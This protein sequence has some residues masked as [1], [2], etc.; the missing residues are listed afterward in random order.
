MKSLILTFC[1]F[2]LVQLFFIVKAEFANDDDDD[3]MGGLFSD[4]STAVPPTG[5]VK[6]PTDELVE[7]QIGL[8]GNTTVV[9]NPVPLHSTITTNC[10]CP[11]PVG[12]HNAAGEQEGCYNIS[13]ISSP[14]IVCYVVK[15]YVENGDWRTCSKLFDV[16][17]TTKNVT[18]VYPS[19]F[20]F[21]LYSYKHRTDW[22]AR[23]KQYKSKISYDCSD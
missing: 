22:G 6:N 15:A 23:A 10:S 19:F 7:P 20:N 17:E 1:F 12:Y 8:E 16:M 9:A 2:T 13:A 14:M 21:T 11:N 3:G 4:S 18:L 5:E